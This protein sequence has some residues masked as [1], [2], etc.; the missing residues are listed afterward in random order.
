AVDLRRPHLEADV[1]VGDDRTEAD[2]QAVGFKQ[3][4]AHQPSPFSPTESMRSR[5]DPTAASTIRCDSVMCRSSRSSA[6]EPRSWIA[7]WISDEGRSSVRRSAKSSSALR[8]SYSSWVD[9]AVGW[10]SRYPPSG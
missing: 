7:A 6:S 8:T 5:T 3:R 1:L 4:Q 9:R 2:R 10:L